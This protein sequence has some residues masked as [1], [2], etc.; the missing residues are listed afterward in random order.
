VLVSDIRSPALGLE[1]LQTLKQ[2]FPDLPVIV[3]TAYSD[4]ESAVAGSRVARS[5]ICPSHSTL[6]GGRAHP[7]RARREHAGK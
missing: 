1:L 5:N 3:M 7:R 2:R 4:L 6:T